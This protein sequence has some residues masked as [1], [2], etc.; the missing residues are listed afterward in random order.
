MESLHNNLHMVKSGVWMAS[1]DRKDAYYSLPIHS[2]YQK[3][4]KFLS[5]YPLK[6]IVMPDDYGPAMRAFKN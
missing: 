2:E 6:F 5:E 1:V 4:L 3:H